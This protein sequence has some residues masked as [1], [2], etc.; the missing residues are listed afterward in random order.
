MEIASRWR[1]LPLVKWISLDKIATHLNPDS[2]I[3][4]KHGSHRPRLPGFSQL[5]GPWWGG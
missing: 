2:L 1:L 4:E 3:S 5:G